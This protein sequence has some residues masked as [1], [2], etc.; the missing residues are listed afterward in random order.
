M[1]SKKIISVWSAL[2]KWS[3]LVLVLVLFQ[4]CQKTPEIQG[5]LFL[6]EGFEAK[7][8][9]DSIAETTRHIAVSPNG[10]VY[11]KFKR[12]SEEGALAALQD[13][14]RDGVAERIEKFA[15]DKSIM[16]RGYATATRVYEG[17]LYFSS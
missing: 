4:Q 8:F 3:V 10:N 5:P 2:G 16:G 11:T 13:L 1:N 14:D 17:Y 12:T 9:I 15:K 6:P 7:V